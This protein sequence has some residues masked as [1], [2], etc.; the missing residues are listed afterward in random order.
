MAVFSQC[1]GEGHPM[2]MPLCGS[3]YQGI[4]FLQMVD[5]IYNES[6]YGCLADM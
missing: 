3:Q 5:A 1:S 6:C 4:I 2:Q